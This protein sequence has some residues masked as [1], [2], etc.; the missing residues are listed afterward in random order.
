MESVLSLTESSTE[1]IQLDF[2]Y[3]SLY[4]SWTSWTIKLRDPIFSQTVNEYNC[5]S[6]KIVTNSQRKRPVSTLENEIIKSI[7]KY[8]PFIRTVYR[9]HEAL[10]WISNKHHFQGIFVGVILLFVLF[11]W[12]VINRISIHKSHKSLKL[13]SKLYIPTLCINNMELPV[14]YAIGLETMETRDE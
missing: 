3:Y 4:M 14:Y 12:F 2:K 6:L 1:V 11:Q 9:L 8:L 5:P 10:G 7:N 13:S